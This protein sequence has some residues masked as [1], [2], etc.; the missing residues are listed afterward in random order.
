MLQDRNKST[1]GL[2]GLGVWVYVLGCR[3]NLY[4]GEA[5]AGELERR[6]AVIFDKPEGCRAAVIVSC[7]VTATADKK[8]RQAVRRAR[9]TVGEE[10]VV[11]VCGCWAQGISLNE[12]RDLGI[13]ILVGNRLK[14]AL[15]DSLEESMSRRPAVPVDMRLDLRTDRVWD[16]L[17]LDH[18]VLR[19]R[20]FL[21]VQE[22]CDRFC[23]YCIIPFLRGRSTSRPPEDTLNEARRVTAAGCSEIVLTGIHLGV[24]GRD[25]QTSL[26]ELVRNLSGVPGLRRLRLGSL[27]PFALDEE[28]LDALAESPVF[29]PHL[30][31]P[32]QSGDDEILAR[33]RR[34]HTADDFARLCDQARRKLGDDLHISGDALVAFPGESEKAFQATLNLM[35]R[36]N[37]GRVHVFPFSPRRGTAA[38]SFP[39]RIPSGVAAERVTAAMELGGDL[40]GRYASRFVGKTVSVLYGY[41]RHFL[42]FA[43]E[44]SEPDAVSGCSGEI[45]GRREIEVRVM[46]CLEGE[47]QVCR[48]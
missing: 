46:G 10:G 26:A 4:E 12:A 43:L 2:L 1:G 18:P 44:S 31:L 23:S 16:S 15:P 14:N 38:A 13:D 29:C 6:G 30:H 45:D 11:A 40:L 41:T 28:L 5:L 27:E 7:A 48:I 17:S 25:R 19:S 34:G 24:Y 20:A 22:G 36:V 9:R 39:D 8:C 42:T 37:L 35:K 47:L 33:M 3:S 21:K 32:F